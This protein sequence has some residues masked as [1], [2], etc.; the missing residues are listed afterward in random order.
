MLVM[1]AKAEWTIKRATA[2]PTSGSLQE[3]RVGG[4]CLSRLR[5]RDG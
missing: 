3:G 1:P 5:R 4:A 2:D